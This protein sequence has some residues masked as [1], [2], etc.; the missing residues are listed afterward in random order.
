M[1]IISTLYPELPLTSFPNEIDSFLTYVNVTASDGPLI[2]QYIDAMNSGNQAQA[3]QIF[4]SIPSATQKIIKATDLNKLSQAILAIERFYK[5]DV[6]PFIQQRQIEWKD[7]IDQFSYKGL[8]ASSTTYQVNNMVSYSVNGLTLLFI[9]TQNP[10]QGTVPTN[11]TYWRQLTIQG[12]QGES[13][14]GLSYRQAWKSSVQ[15]YVNDAVTHEGCLWQSLQNNQNTKPGTNNLYWKLIVKFTTAVYPI[16]DTPPV[17]QSL[18][19][20]WF[21]TSVDPINYYH[22][23]PLFNPATASQ[24]DAGFEAYDA[25]GNRIIGTRA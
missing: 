20:L 9:V 8:W 6:E 15:Y 18:G 3:N 25:Q 1:V 17:V 16:Q 4:A 19:E 21:N 5:T 24:I 2:K 7:Y 22:L 12:Q 23:E 13:G 14:I 10:P 11:K